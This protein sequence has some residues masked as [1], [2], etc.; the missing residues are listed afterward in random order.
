MPMSMSMSISISISISKPKPTHIQSLSIKQR[1]PKY[2]IQQTIQSIDLT[3]SNSAEEESVSK[4]EWM[5]GRTAAEALLLLLS[6]MWRGGVEED[7]ERK[8]RVK[9]EVERCAFDAT[10]PPSSLNLQL[11][12]SNLHYRT[13]GFLK[14]QGGNRVC[15][16]LM[17]S[18]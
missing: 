2:I 1:A 4:G 18:A 11:P 12:T 10:I 3:S 7:L 5:N 15:Y 13:K 9:M 14:S 8:Q 16:D 17:C 6:S